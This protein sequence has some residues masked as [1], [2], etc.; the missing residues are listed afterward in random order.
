MHSFY[1]FCP[2]EFY[3]PLFPIIFLLSSFSFSFPHFLSSPFSIFHKND[4]DL[5]TPTR[6]GGVKSFPIYT[7]HPLAQLTTSAFTSYVVWGTVSDKHGL[8]PDQSTRLYGCYYEMLV[9]VVTSTNSCWVGVVVYLVCWSFW[10]DRAGQGPSN[11]QPCARW[12]RWRH[13]NISIYIHT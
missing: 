12:S 13:A 11:I 7:V 9:N 6:A 3:F 8:H 10:Q 4:I 5:Y 1:L 2:F